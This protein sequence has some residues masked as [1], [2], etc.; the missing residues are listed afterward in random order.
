MI[1]ITATHLKVIPTKIRKEALVP[2][3]IIDLGCPGRYA[4]I[5]MIMIL[6]SKQLVAVVDKWSVERCIQENYWLYRKSF[7]VETS[8]SNTS[9]AGHAM[10][11]QW[12]AGDPGLG[13]L[14]VMVWR[15]RANHKMWEFIGWQIMH[16]VIIRGKAT[17]KL[18]C[19]CPWAMT[20]SHWATSM[21]V[22]EWLGSSSSLSSTPVPVKANTSARSVWL[23][24]G[25]SV[26]FTSRNLTDFNLKFTVTIWARS[27]LKLAGGLIQHNTRFS[28]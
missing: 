26:A 5:N 25:S 28:G 2:V 18:Y 19:S 13:D 27:V 10:M 4:S 9:R 23:G 12:L 16:H 1:C 7:Y 8:I 20:R 22:F 6:I 14:S 24:H 17:E 15:Q 21:F 11:V 3:I